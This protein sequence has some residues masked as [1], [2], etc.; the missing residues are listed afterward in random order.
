MSWAVP[1]DEIG[2]DHV[3]HEIRPIKRC[4]KCVTKSAFETG[5][6]RS[7][8]LYKVVTEIIWTLVVYV[9]S[10]RHIKRALFRMDWKLGRFLP[11]CMPV[12]WNVGLMSFTSLVGRD[13]IVLFCQG[14]RLRRRVVPPTRRLVLLEC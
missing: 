14:N 1:M 6:E 9:T 3:S 2:D 4:R 13:L 12:C 7:E 11:T 8:P 5:G 10:Y